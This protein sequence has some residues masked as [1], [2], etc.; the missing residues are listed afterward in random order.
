MTSPDPRMDT[1]LRVLGPSH[2]YLGVLQEGV[3]VSWRYVGKVK[4]RKIFRHFSV[5]SGRMRLHSCTVGWVGNSLREGRVFALR[6]S[7]IVQ[8]ADVT[9]WQ[10]VIRLRGTELSWK[11]S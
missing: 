11:R 6:I 5:D 2:V 10:A 1:M 9:F 3:V 7:E 4:K 8:G